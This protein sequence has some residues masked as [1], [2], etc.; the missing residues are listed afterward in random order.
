MAKNNSNKKKIKILTSGPITAIGYIWGPVLTPYYEDADVIFKLL[1]A[2]TKIVEV[3]DDGTEVELTLQNYQSDNSKNARDKK[4]KADEEAAKAAKEAK[5]KK[6][7][8]AKAK[9]EAAE[10]EKAAKAAEAKKAEKAKEELKIDAAVDV[11]E[12]P[13]R[14]DKSK[15]GYKK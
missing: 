6:E 9:K 8:E 13:Q 1:S 11:D 7:A 4:A 2:G 14:D 15:G 10:A 3:T 5:E 12:L